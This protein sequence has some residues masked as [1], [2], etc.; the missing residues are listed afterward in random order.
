[1]PSQALLL[2]VLLLLAGTAGAAAFLFQ[3]L[4]HRIRLIENSLGNLDSKNQEMGVGHDRRFDYLEERLRILDVRRGVGHLSDLV[5]LAERNGELS[6]GTVDE[7]LTYLEGLAE[8]VE[9]SGKVPKA[10]SSARVESP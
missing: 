8:Q 6:V 5:R 2:L 1:M 7:M 3:R 10:E 4:R 9:K